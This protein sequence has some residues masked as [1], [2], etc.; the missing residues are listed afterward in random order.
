MECKAIEK[1]LLFYIEGELN[2]K[3]EIEVESHLL[4]CTTCKSKYNFIKGSMLL[5]ESEKKMEINPFLY[6]RIQG[7]LDAPVVSRRQRV[8]V[9]VLMTSVLVVGLFIGTLIGQITVSP[10]LSNETNYEV[11]YLFNDTQLEGLEYKLL[12]DKE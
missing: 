1:K 5:I 8:F 6:T 12:N 11:A 7:K 9:P 2:D 10:K 3:D 4:T